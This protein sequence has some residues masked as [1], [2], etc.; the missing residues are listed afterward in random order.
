MFRRSIWVIQPKDGVKNPNHAVLQPSDAVKN[1]IN[2][3][4]HPSI[5]VR[6]PNHP[7]KNPSHD[8]RAVMDEIPLGFTERSLQTAS[9][10]EGEG[11]SVNA[12]F[13]EIANSSSKAFLP[14]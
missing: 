7:V 5:W 11:G 6:N 3:V 12:F 9:A 10:G 8:Y 2:R 1:R 4:N 14:T 13:R